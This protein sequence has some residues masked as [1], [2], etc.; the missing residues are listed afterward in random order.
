MQKWNRVPISI[1]PAQ[2]KEIQPNAFEPKAGLFTRLIVRRRSRVRVELQAG[3]LPG[4]R[5]ISKVTEPVLC[6]ASQ[7]NAPLSSLSGPKLKRAGCRDMLAPAQS[8]PANRHCA[9]LL[10]ALQGSFVSSPPSITSFHC[11]ALLSTALDRFASSAPTLTCQDN[12]NTVIFPHT[13][14]AHHVRLRTTP[15]K[16]EHSCRARRRW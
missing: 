8:S 11:P 2:L 6:P 4:W 14:V 1:R 16:E 7:F 13:F 5:G 15:R 3:G 12:Q 10:K 9:S